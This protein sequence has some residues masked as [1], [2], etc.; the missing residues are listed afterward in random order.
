M[1]KIKQFIYYGSGSSF[2]H[3]Q[4]SEINPWVINLF[5]SY[6]QIT[7]LGIQ[8]EPG[9][10]FCLN[11]STNENAI[12]L[13]ATGIYEINLEG[14]GYITSLRFLPE[15]LEEYYKTEDTGHRLIVDFVYE[16]GSL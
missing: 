3:P 4:D 8:G 16:G 14:M 1:K 11:N 9:V 13:G 6:K 2:N 5:T 10:K 12:S 7:H 15:S